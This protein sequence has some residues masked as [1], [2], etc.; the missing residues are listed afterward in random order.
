[1]TS[2]EAA[3]AGQEIERKFVVPRAPDELDAYPSEVLEQ[4]YL[5]VSPDGVEVRI[6]KQGD[7]TT[8]TVKSSGGLTRLEETIDIEERAF[9]ALWP[10]TRGRRIHKTRY[11]LPTEGDH[12]IELDMYAG[13]LEGLVTAEVEFSSEAESRTFKPPAWFGTEV[14]EDPRYRNRTLALEGKP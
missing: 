13:E 8:L 2:E 4:G 14:T 10:L 1:M 3:V 7:R 9:G 11:T 5:A 6:R 12:V